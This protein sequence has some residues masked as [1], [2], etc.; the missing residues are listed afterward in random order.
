MCNVISVITKWFYLAK[1]V[2]VALV[3]GLVDRIYKTISLQL[4]LLKRGVLL[5][6]RAGLPRLGLVHQ[7]DVFCAVAEEP[8]PDA[9][10]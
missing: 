6:P 2:F 5:Q 10:S 9:V 7:L 1:G 4:K 3:A 8:A